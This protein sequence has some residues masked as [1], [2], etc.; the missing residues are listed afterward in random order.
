MFNRGLFNV[1]RFN[2][3]PF[4]IS[5]VVIGEVEGSGAG[6]GFRKKRK[7]RFLFSWK[8]TGDVKRFFSL[9]RDLKGEIIF[10]DILDFKL[11]GTREVRFEDFVF[12]EGEKLLFEDSVLFTTGI[13]QIS[14]DDIYN[15]ETSKKLSFFC[16]VDTKGQILNR[17][18]QELDI[19]GIRKSEERFNTELF[20]EKLLSFRDEIKFTGRRD[21][22]KFLSALLTLD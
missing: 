4:R 19:S 15:L 9:F 20:G 5:I 16:Y 7:K 1:F 10:F 12:C 21:I 6:D 8:V 3:V 22:R 18:F 2:S 11:K 14:F 13:K 17:L